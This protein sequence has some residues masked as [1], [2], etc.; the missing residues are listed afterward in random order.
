MRK[1]IAILM[2]IALFVSSCASST[3]VRKCNGQRGVKVPMG[4]L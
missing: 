3:H 1:L 2:I 4:V